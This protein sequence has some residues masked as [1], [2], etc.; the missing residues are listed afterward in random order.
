[1]L[2]RSLRR[3]PRDVAWLAAWSAVEALP[4]LVS[5]WVI[6]EAIGHFLAGRSAGAFGWLSLLALAALAGACGTRQATVRLGALVEPLRDELVGLIVA[7][8]LASSMG[9]AKPPDTDAVA[10]M[11][12]QA[13]I[14]RDSYA[15]VLSVARRFV[16][17][18]GSTLIG[19]LTLVPAV[20]PYVVP[21]LVVSVLFLRLLL[22]PFAA[23]QRRSV[24]GEELVANSAAKAVSGLRDV[25]A[26][27]A[28]DLVLAGLRDRIMSQ[29][30]ATR[31]VARVGAARA[32]CVAA[33]GWLPLLL[34]LAAAPSMLHHGVPPAR[35]IGAIVY[36]TGSLRGMLS[37]LSQGVGSGLVRL[38][39]TLQRIVEASAGPA[40]SAAA[41]PGP[42]ADGGHEGAGDLRLRDVTFGYGE[43]SEPVIDGLSL[44]IEAG[45]HLA[46]VG[47]S[48][49]GKSTL[50]GLLAGM[51]CPTAGEILLDGLSLARYPLGA[52][53]ARRVLI[54]QEAYVFAG[55]LA[56]NIRYLRAAS[57]A[58]LGAAAEAVGL[59]P[60]VSR[61]G[62]YDATLNPAALSAGE[63]QLIALAR[64]YL[65]AAPIAILDEATCHLD[66]AAE[67]RAEGAFATRPGT[68]I[69]VAHRISSALRAKRVLVLDG[70]RALVGDHAW[71]LASSAM[72]RSLVGYW[73]W[74]PE[75]DIAPIRVAPPTGLSAEGNCLWPREESPGLVVESSLRPRPGTGDR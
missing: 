16:F 71:L 75:S 26:C 22:G 11:T 50:A 8:A 37:A 14:V 40:A 13:E 48:G 2:T 20:L 70:T 5:G 51:L 72:Y 49:V 56:E 64:A 61:L 43:H 52:L 73:A 30:D 17:T 31:S 74:R 69:V 66:P 53:P 25:T 57:T 21:P 68:L 27:G 58:E 1:M 36:I 18:A 12:H 35:I 24:I 60:L 67:A 10:R 4:A 39:V 62:G 3:R 33:G 29:A 28:E 45:E 38:T 63:R 9:T 47:P 46:I 15:G 6:A 7:G 23:R 44:D 42:D 59:S 34:V 32:L 19:L 65:S 55:T 41:L 54:P